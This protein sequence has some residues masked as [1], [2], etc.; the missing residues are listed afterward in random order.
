LLTKGFELGTFGYQIGG[1]VLA[2]GPLSRLFD[3]IPTSAFII[4]AM[5]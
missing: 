5:P 4:L 2:W 3:P 1:I